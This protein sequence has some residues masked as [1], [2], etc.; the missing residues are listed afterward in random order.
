MSFLNPI[1]FWLFC[2]IPLF[3]IAYYFKNK[4]YLPAINYSLPV[5]KSYG[6]KAKLFP[7]LFLL[8]LLAIIFIIIALARPQSTEVSQDTLKKEGIDIMIAMDIS[9]SMLAQDFEPNRLE[10]AKELAI[11]FIKRR[12]NDRIGL[13]T[14]SSVSFTQCPLTTDHDVLINM[15]TKVKTGILTDGT[16]IG[17]G[18]ANCVNRLKDSKAESKIIILLTDGEN[19]SGVIDPISA[20]SMAREFGIKTYT[21]GVGSYGTAPYPGGY[22]VRS[23]IDD[24]ML[25]LVADTTG[26]VYFRADKRSELAR[27]YEEIELLEKTEIEEIKFYNVTEKYFMFCLL[28]FLFFVLE[29]LFDYTIFKRI[30]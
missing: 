24:D 16:A 11:D 27:V 8:R 22:T 10:S 9:S 14:Y 6:V 1:F 30:I 19:N 17:V 3:L 26:G 7:I 13:V 5:H 29:L 21:I 25:T 28:A 4:T 20:A 12:K 2:L 15:M 23:S 18:I